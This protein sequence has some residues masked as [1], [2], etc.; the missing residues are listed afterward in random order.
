MTPKQWCND[1]F[2][3]PWVD[4]SCGPDS[5]DC[6]GLVIDSFKRIDGVT[7][8]E[9]SGYNDGEPV[10]SIGTKEAVSWND[11][12][13]KHGAVFCVVKMGLVL[14]VGRILAVGGRLMACHSAGKDGKGQVIIEP[15]S[16]LE[17]KYKN[18]LIYKQG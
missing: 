5:Y 16:A 15:L 9:V 2:G 8:P 3:K 17:R 18:N 6:W 1:V 12:E 14:H 10:E 4:R 11:C 7:L 13:A